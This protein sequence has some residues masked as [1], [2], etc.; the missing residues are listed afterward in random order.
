MKDIHLRITDEHYD[1]L[2]ENSKKLGFK[3]IEEFAYY[4][5]KYH[6]SHTDMLMNLETNVKKI[7]K[8]FNVEYNTDQNT[9]NPE[10]HISRFKKILSQRT[11]NA[12]SSTVT[13]IDE[14]SF[15]SEKDIRK[16]RNLGEKSFEEVVL[17]IDYLSNK[18]LITRE[19]YL[20]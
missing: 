10:L 2:K 6:E 11:F 18:G 3:S 16:I 13:Y 17:L 9:G 4:I 5:I 1:Y 12:L 14:L 15:R 20:F 19:D 7:L 8:Y